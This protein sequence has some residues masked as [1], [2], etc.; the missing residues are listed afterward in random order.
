MRMVGT[1]RGNDSVTAPTEAETP[2]SR[3]TECSE[4]L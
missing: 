1:P 3:I 4:T 2:L